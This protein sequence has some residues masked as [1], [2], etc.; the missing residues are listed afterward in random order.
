MRLQIILILLISFPIGCFGQ[1]RQDFFDNHVLFFH[2]ALE[3]GKTAHDLEKILTKSD[4]ENYDIYIAADST[5]QDIKWIENWE[6]SVRD[7]ILS[8]LKQKGYELLAN[9]SIHQ[10]G[11]PKA[12]DVLRNC[13][14]EELLYLT[15]AT[16]NKVHCELKHSPND[17][18]IVACHKEDKPF[19][20]GWTLLSLPKIEDKT[21]DSGFIDIQLTLDR[22][23]NVLDGKI[24]SSS[25]DSEIT[26]KYFEA[27]KK[28]KFRRIEGDVKSYSVKLHHKKIK[29]RFKNYNN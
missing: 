25:I 5:I 3:T 18:L 29:I 6:V 15:Y 23:G 22:E 26:L 27:F 2:R 10:F 16:T 8:G 13:E 11:L 14:A 17:E 20:Y 12:A 1:S 19:K 4:I 24:I 21:R 9:K 28:V 7:S